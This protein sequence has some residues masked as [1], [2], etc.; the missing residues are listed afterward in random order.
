ML[1]VESG[2]NR[3]GELILIPGREIAQKDLVD[4]DA[5]LVR[6]ITQVGNDL[7]EDT[8]VRFVG[9]ATSGTDHIDLGYLAEN[10]IGFAD[11]RGSNANAVVDYCFS[12]LAHMVINKGL[13][14]YS[15]TVGIV[16]AGN[17]GSLFANK[18]EQLNIAYRLCDPPLQHAKGKISNSGGSVYHSLR[19]TLQCNVVTLHVP[20]TRGGDYPTHRLVNNKNLQYLPEG[21]VLINTSRGSVVDEAAL[22]KFLCQRDDVSCVVDVWENEPGVSKELARQVEIATPHIAGYSRDAKFAA[23][24]QLSQVFRDFFGITSAD[25]PNQELPAVVAVSLNSEELDTELMHWHLI[26]SAFPIAKLSEQFIQSVAGNRVSEAFDQLRRNLVRRREF[27]SMSV[28]GRQL[29]AGQRKLLSVL[30]FNIEVLA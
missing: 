3:F 9:S 14:I 23:T 1:A 24:V 13:D 6:S 26:D 27:R 17:I 29:H 25:E 8:R 22:L 21:A 30:G 10:E 20:L 28:S 11:A 2:F 16:G 7:L 4:A 18:L 5:L 15:S 12:A 19:E